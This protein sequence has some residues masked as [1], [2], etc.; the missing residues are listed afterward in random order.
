MPVAERVGVRLA[1]E[2]IPNALSTAR[3]AGPT[4]RGRLELPALGICLDVGHARLQGDVV[5]A[6]ETV[7]G[8]SRH[9]PPA[10]QRR[11]QGRPLLPF[12]GVI[13]WPELLIALPEGRLRRHPDVRLAAGA[14]GPPRRCAALAPCGAASSRCSGRTRS[15]SAKSRQAATLSRPF[16]RYAGYRQR[17]CTRRAG[18]TAC[19]RCRPDCPG[20]GSP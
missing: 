16:R 14:D 20:T 1:V 11:P 17:R 13:D 3:A 6:L 10:R 8:L 4:H 9:D 19:C 18:P 2:V 7:A 15:R 12:D 5:D